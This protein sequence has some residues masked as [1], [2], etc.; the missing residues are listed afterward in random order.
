MSQS[1]TKQLMI[2]VSAASLLAGGSAFAQAASQELVEQTVPGN[3]IESPG[4][5]NPR[6]PIEFSSDNLAFDKEK[7]VIT[8]QGNVILTHKGRRV[9]AER[10]VYNIDEDKL[11]AFD[12]IV[13]TE[14]NGDQFIADYLILRDEFK[15][16]VIQ[17]LRVQLVDDSRIWAKTAERN[18]DVFSF[19]GARYTPCKPCQESKEGTKGKEETPP[20]QIKAKDVIWDQEEN[21]ITYKNARFEVGGVPVLYTPYFRHP[22]GTVKQ[23]SGL[24]RPS[25]GY[26]SQ[27]G[28]YWDQSYY[29]GIDESKDAT[30]GVIGTTKEA[31]VATAEYR[32]HFGNGE[33]NV[34]GS[35]T[36]SGRT[37]NINGTEIVRDKELRGHVFA[38]ARVDL[39]ENWRAGADLNL[40]TDEQYLR[41]YDFDDKIE[42][43]DILTSQIYAERFSGRNYA[44]ARALSF[45]D[46]R[47]A[48]FAN[49]DQPIVVPMIEADFYGKPNATFGGRWRTQASL[50]NLV[51]D[52]NNQDVTRAVAQADWERRFTSSQ[53]IATTVN[54]SLRGDAFFTND[55]NPATLN[56]GQDNSDES[57]R[58][59]PRL[60]VVSQYPLEREFKGGKWLVE[61]IV[62]ATF[63]PNMSEDPA[64]PNEDSL[65]TQLDITNL[66]DANRFTGLDRIEDRSHVTYGIKTGLY[67]NSGN[68][69]DVFIGQSFRLEEEG[70]TFQQGSGL[71]NEYSDFVGGVRTR[72]NNKYDLNYRFQLDGRQLQSRR[73]EA[74]AQYN[75]D[76]FGLSAYYFFVDSIAS[77]G[78]TESRE[79]ITTNA[80]W[81]VDDNWRLRN[82]TVY[83]LGVDKTGLLKTNFG[84]DYLAECYTLSF[85]AE[86]NFTD[87]SSGESDTSITFRIG[88]KNLSEFDD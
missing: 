31:A 47:V 66:F 20:W 37:D 69:T 55:I 60:H 64:I 46:I 61:P 16:G 6:I 33:F 58:L 80:Y 56:P 77:A 75:G 50:L 65:D 8:A 27:L 49:E 62:A 28:A 54:T 83:D 42:D 10:V 72:I 39:N 34:E 43:D 53:G 70:N 76:R 71:S 2:S 52:G 24:L 59:F 26:K 21:T 12:N 4:I 82:Y 38:E 22:D 14:K 3:E 9:D 68:Y 48:Q 84:V 7:N 5:V 44:R 87:E 78:F 11:E 1:L 18:G 17:K 25:F 88:L 40:T 13:L 29:F 86:R 51:R 15:Q 23:K 32:Q 57:T 19:K 30:I 81:N 67:Q 79:Q 73:H 36:N 63:S 45:Q 74:N 35:L 41:Q 85:N